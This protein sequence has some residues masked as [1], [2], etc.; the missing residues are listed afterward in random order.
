MLTLWYDEPA[1]AWEG[2]VLPIGNGA[3]GAC[4]FGTLGTE[5]LQLNEKSLW[6]GGPGGADPYDF[7]RWPQDRRAAL[8][9]VRRAIDERGSVSP[10]E[11]AEL[12]GNPAYS[13]VG[14]IP[15]FGA[16]QNF[17]ELLLD[18]PGGC[19]GGYRRSLDLETAVAS[20][21]YE[22]ADGVPVS[23]E[24]FASYPANVVVGRVTGG[25]TLRFASTR[26]AGVTAEGGRLRVRGALA[27]NGLVYEAQVQ[28][29]GACTTEGDRVTAAGDAWFVFSA[30]TDHA[31][32]HPHYRG[33]D[34]AA[35]VTAAVDAAA[36]RTYEEL[37]AEHVADHREL[38]GRVRL[39]LGQRMPDLPTDR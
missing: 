26:A 10:E 27:D 37:R 34:P 28:V 15:G 3:L 8:E 36:R 4:V 25:F 38:F 19:S 13:T 31:L 14:R 1:P 30:G 23:R 5:R 2:H 12:L 24:Y 39:D 20:V 22:D 32:A 6:T 9:S 7:G 18:V 17:G 29:V 33:E 21:A 11:A 35:R 16:Y